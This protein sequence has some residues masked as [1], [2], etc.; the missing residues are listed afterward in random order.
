MNIPSS[1]SDR[2]Y[3]HC[4]KSSYR[5]KKKHWCKSEV[6]KFNNKKEQTYKKCYYFISSLTQYLCPFPAKFFLFSFSTSKAKPNSKALYNA[7]KPTLKDPPKPPPCLAVTDRRLHFSLLQFLSSSSPPSYY[8]SSSTPS[9]RFYLSP[10]RFSS[11][12]FPW[13]KAGTPSTFY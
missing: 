4:C 6:T 8:F 1:S 2:C 10:L 9:L 7:T 3:K 13:R 12:P 5:K 11:P